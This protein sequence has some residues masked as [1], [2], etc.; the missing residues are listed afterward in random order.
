MERTLKVNR[1]LFASCHGYVD[2]SSGAA[3]STR[4]L[5]ELFAARGI[6]ARV[7]STGILDYARETPLVQVLDR[8][9]ASYRRA[10]ALQSHDPGQ[11]AEGQGVTGGIEVFDLELDGVRVTL[12]PTSSSRIG[13]S[14]S[15]A[16]SAAFLD[17]ADQVFDRFRPQVLLTYGGHAVCRE[18]IARARRRGIAVVFHLRNLEYSGPDLFEHVNG[19]VVTTEFARRH[20]ERVLGRRCEVI[21]NPLRRDRVVAEDVA[22][23]YLTF[24][25]PQVHKGAAVFARIAVELARRRPEI[26]LLVVEGRGMAD[27][28]SRVGLD[29]SGLHNLHRMSNTPDPRDFYRVSRA[30]LMPSLCRET[31]GR[32]A[33]EAMANGIPVLASDRGALPETVGDGGFVLPVPDRCTPTSG[34]VPTIAEAGP[35]IEVIERLWDDAVWERT[36]RSR[37]L[38][39][40]RRWDPDRVLEQY[41][42]FFQSLVATT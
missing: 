25:N 23:R 37:A 6:D 21:P 27:D 35:W 7:L 26:P 2:P 16:E 31:F 20:Y 14:P 39:A 38:D 8:L 18:L 15:P 29:L 1:I 42:A 11:A 3:V 33:A 28:L 36:Q 41:E 4:D 19:V 9:E 32:V 10:L 17:L 12:M 22:P 24:V 30:V 40:S 34:E 5:M 13:R